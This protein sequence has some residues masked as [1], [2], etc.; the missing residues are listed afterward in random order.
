MGQP[1]SEVEG[2]RPDR[3]AVER[4]RVL[5]RRS[6]NAEDEGEFIGRDPR[7]IPLAD[8][9]AAGVEASGVMQA[10][11]PKCLDCVCHQPGEVR[12]CVAVTCPLWP[13]R[14]GTDVFHRKRTSLGKMRR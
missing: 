2:Q 1:K 4:R 10:I 5:L 11:R 7:K 8:W 9:R 3:R 14:M 12:K 6:P 13:F